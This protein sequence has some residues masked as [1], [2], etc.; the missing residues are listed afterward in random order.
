MPPKRKRRSP[1]PVTQADHARVRELHEQ[2][3]SRN[4]IARDLD[5][6]LS[7]VT[8]IARVE[9][10]AFDREQTKAA[11]AAKVADSRARRAEISSQLLDDVQRLRERAWS[12]YSY[13]EKTPTKPVRVTLDL[14]PLAEVRHAY[15]SIGVAIDRHVTLERHDSDIGAEGARS[16]LGALAAGLMVAADQIDGAGGEP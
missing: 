9:G 6:S 11:T 5:R 1:R 10:L 16:V 2:G 14:P 13:Y 12:Q 3:L 7:I 15:S 4:A 8:K